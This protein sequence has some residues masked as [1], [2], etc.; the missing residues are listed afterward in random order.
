M[1]L[2]PFRKVPA[3]DIM[4]MFSSQYRA[5]NHVPEASQK[6]FDDGFPLRIVEHCNIDKSGTA[7]L[8][9]HE[10]DFWLCLY[11][12]ATFIV[13]GRLVNPRQY[14]KDRRTWL[15]D[16]I[17]DGEVVTLNAGDYFHVPAGQ[18]H[19]PTTRG[20]A[21]LVIIKV[22]AKEGQIKLDYLPS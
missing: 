20:S 12:E 3:D 22:Q 10:D 14:E 19:Q 8:H 11:G 13:G 9:L 1:E 15:G 2:R 4:R 6:L 21:R 7:E 5:G 18:P 17:E 16:S